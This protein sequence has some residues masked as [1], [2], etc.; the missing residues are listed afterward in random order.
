M[1]FPNLTMLEAFARANAGPC[2]DRPRIEKEGAHLEE[3]LTNARR[4]ST[5]S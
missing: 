2:P 3:K 4:T 5:T 1:T